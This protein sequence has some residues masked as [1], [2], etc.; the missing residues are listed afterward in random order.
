MS[1][2]TVPDFGFG[3]RPRGPSFFP[4]RPTMPIMSGVAMATSNS[5]QPASIFLTRSSPPTSSAPAAQRLLRL[6]ALGEDDDARACGRCRAAGRPCRAR[7]GRRG[8]G[9]CPRRRCSSTVAS[10]LREREAR[11]RARRPRAICVAA[12][13][14][15]SASRPRGTSSVAC[16]Q[17][18]HLDAHAARR[19]GD[20]P[21]R[22]LDVVGVEVRHLQSRRSRAAAPATRVPTLS[23]FGS[24]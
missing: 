21:H 6:L 1:K 4:S 2:V 16:H 24:R 19:A 8:A 7:A 17:S 22:V 11:Q 12:L 20:D 13:R 5:N 14:P 15:R 10:N 3:I 18:V 23:R 9:R